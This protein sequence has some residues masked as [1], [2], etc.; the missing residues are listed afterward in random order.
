E[1]A[2]GGERHV[3]R[4]P[5]TFC[6]QPRAWPRVTAERGRSATGPTTPLR[7]ER[8]P[9]RATHLHG[10]AEVHSHLAECLQGARTVTTARG[11]CQARLFRPRDLQSLAIHCSTSPASLGMAAERLRIPLPVTRTSSS[12]RTPMPR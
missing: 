1:R 3:D 12:M 9:A 5:G 7:G 4:E 10:R 6:C 11:D 2:G 8:A